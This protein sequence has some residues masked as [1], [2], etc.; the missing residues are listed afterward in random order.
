MSL[1]QSVQHMTAD[2]VKVVAL[3][4]TEAYT[5]TGLPQSQF[6]KFMSVFICKYSHR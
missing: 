4:V 2:Q 6:A 3:L 5:K 1:L